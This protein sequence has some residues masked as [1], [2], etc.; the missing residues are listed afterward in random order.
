M[1]KNKI[2][3]REG[4]YLVA[5][6]GDEDTVTGFLMAGVGKKDAKQSNYFV[7]SSK[8]TPLQAIEEAFIGFTNRDDI[9]I[10]LINQFI[11]NQIRHVV[12]NFQKPVPAILEIP[13]KE[14]PYQPS[15]DSILQRVR[16]ML[17]NT[18]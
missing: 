3:N 6:I 8:E 15:K 14:H 10:I 7:V 5:V 17:G 11:A 13:S 4:G 1:S 2:V 16:N 12:N 9:A 18:D